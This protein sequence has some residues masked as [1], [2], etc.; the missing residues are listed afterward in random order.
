MN[1]E[2]S[3]LKQEVASNTE[4]LKKNRNMKRE[5]SARQPKSI[6]LLTWGPLFACY[7]KDCAYQQ[8]NECG[9]DR[10]F[11]EANMCNIERSKD[12]EVIV[13]KY[14]NVLGRS[15]GMQYEIVEV[16]MNGDELIEHLIHYHTK[17]AIPHEVGHTTRVECKVECTRKNSMCKHFINGSSYTDD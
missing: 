15:R 6:P 3:R 4:K 13:R 2:A 10:F 5:G 9:I 12:V 16:K 8:C 17:L 1:V 7:Y 11:N 14:E